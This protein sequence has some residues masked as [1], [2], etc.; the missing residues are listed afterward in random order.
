MVIPMILQSLENG[1]EVWGL[2]G[3]DDGCRSRGKC[4][5]IFNDGYS[6]VALLQGAH[7]IA[8]VAEVRS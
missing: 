3:G 5:V 6:E 8:T 1:V 4:T 7:V 2:I